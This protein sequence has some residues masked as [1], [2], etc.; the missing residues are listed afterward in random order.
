MKYLYQYYTDYIYALRH[1]L[2]QTSIGFAI[3][4]L[5]EAESTRI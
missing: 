2:K 1:M 5:H 4:E 3:T